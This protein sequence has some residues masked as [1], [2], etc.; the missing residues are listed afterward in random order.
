[1]PV[2]KD[3]VDRMFR[4]VDTKFK[5]QKDFAAAIG[6]DASH[7]SRWR[8][9]KS[10]SYVKRLE[11]ISRV[12]GVTPQ[13]LLSG[14]TS[15]EDAASKESRADEV[16]EDDLKA[17]FWGGDKDLSPEDLD[18]MWGDVKRFAAFIAQQ[19]RQ[20]KQQHD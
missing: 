3:I 20:E 10:S 2:D 5:E 4:L 17:A 9:R 1:M 12:L 8:N 13:Y 6:V 11:K 18:A 15:E 14:G 19:K 7:I 16:S